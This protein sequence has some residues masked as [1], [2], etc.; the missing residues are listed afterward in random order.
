MKYINAFLLTLLL[1]IFLTPVAYAH[2]GTETLQGGLISGFFHPLT[3]LDHI[4]AMFAVGLW[5]VILGKPAYWLLPV[6]F[7]IVMALG[8]VLGVLGI[9]VPY[10]EAGIAL[11]GIILGIMVAFTIKPPIWVAAVIVGIFA[12]FH[13][14]AHG[15]ELPKA[16]NPLIFS[17][18]FVV[19]TGLLHLTGIAF[20]ELSRWPVGKTLVRG[21][22]GII[23]LVGMG[24]LTGYMQ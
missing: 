24:F 10:T 9:P 14:Y 1:S 17:I 21:L 19:S 7:P 12:V 4:V 16:S 3:G 8:G 2:A 23:T 13:G 5:G 22:G 6:V 20:G 18:G 15:V 11:S